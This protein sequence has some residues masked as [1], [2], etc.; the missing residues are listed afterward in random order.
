ML[1]SI[2]LMPAIASL[3]L[4]A[5]AILLTL[6]GC[7]TVMGDSIMDQGG[8]RGAP[9]VPP[10][11]TVVDG[12]GNPAPELYPN[13]MPMMQDPEENLQDTSVTIYAGSKSEAE[14]QCSEE[15]LRRSDSTTIVNCLGCVKMTATTDRYACTLRI[16]S[17]GAESSPEQ[18]PET[19]TGET[20][21]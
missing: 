5:G 16:E 2:V 20:N 4:P 14:K 13:T 15:A 11:P 21:E 6:T 7:G 3:V 8:G 9:I 17:K 1:K 10:V 19:P 18:Y 12:Y